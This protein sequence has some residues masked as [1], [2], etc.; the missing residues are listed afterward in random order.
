VTDD[1]LLA[2][3]QRLRR[4]REA[5][6]PA[7]RFSDAEALD[8]RPVGAQDDVETGIDLRAPEPGRDMSPHQKPPAAPQ[9]RWDMV[10]EYIQRMQ[11]EAA[12]DIAEA[13]ME[14]ARRRDIG[15]TL[16]RGGSQMA[17]A[18]LGDRSVLT[19]PVAVSAAEEAARKSNDARR[20]ALQQWAER[21]SRR[22]L[23]AA[24]LLREAA[25]GEAAEESSARRDAL[26]EDE[27]QRRR[28][29]AQQEAGFAEE[30]LD[31][32]RQAE[33]RK[34][35]AVGAG[36]AAQAR[37]EIEERAR[38]E[39]VTQ[40]ER[41]SAEGLPYGYRMKADANPLTKT[42]RE[43]IAAAVVAQA[44]V[45][46]PI[47]R[48][49]ELTRGGL[50][51]LADPAARREVAQYAEQIK[52][53]IR[54]SENLGVPSGADAEIQLKLVG[55]PQSPLNEVSGVLPKLLSNLRDYFAN[56]VNAKIDK[57]GVEKIPQAEVEIDDPENPGT[58]I[59]VRPALA[60]KLRKKAAK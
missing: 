10:R 34:R 7:L 25:S 57:L 21:K 40:R 41:K 6:A 4:Q 22:E 33:A 17:A 14:A 42:Q 19:Q 2:A 16:L 51:R 32:L 15:D 49:E 5:G 26:L 43:D 44:E 47:R 36:G 3:L 60:E 45:E 11:G 52:T 18:F 35:A 24:G 13:D 59:S 38:A 48:L 29:R 54:V 50:T 27:T 8:L 55:D 28:E 20:A 31:I 46:V 23:E 58:T 56:K 39:R 1:E 30:K 9:S 53:A 37:R 12:P